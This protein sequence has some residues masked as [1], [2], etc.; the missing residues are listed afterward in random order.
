MVVEAVRRRC[1][2]SNQV[3]QHGG[4][5]QRGSCQPLR[6]TT[7]RPQDDQTGRPQDDH[8]TTQRGGRKGSN[9]GAHTPLRILED[10]AMPLAMPSVG[11]DPCSSS[12]ART[13][14][15]SRWRQQAATTTT[16][17]L[18]SSSRPGD[19]QA[20]QAQTARGGGDRQARHSDQAT[21][22]A[23][24]QAGT[25]ATGWALL[26]EVLDVGGY[27]DY[28]TSSESSFPVEKPPTVVSFG[29]E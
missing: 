25:R 26:V 22:T 18:F 20:Q 11:S 9:A 2:A 8:R 23:S 28:G 27:G 15:A 17:R 19:K 3:Q 29:P 14:R 6:T 13:P 4:S 5:S 21:G 24:G 7:G 16:R 1:H 12:T 10:T